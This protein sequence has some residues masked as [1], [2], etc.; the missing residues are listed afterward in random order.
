MPSFSLQYG[1]YDVVQSDGRERTVR[2]RAGDHKGFQAN[3]SYNNPQ[4]YVY[5]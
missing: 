3:V 4:G 1:F 5:Q 2:Y